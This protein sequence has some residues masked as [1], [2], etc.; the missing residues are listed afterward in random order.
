[1]IEV[2]SESLLRGEKKKERRKKANPSIFYFSFFWHMIHFRY[3]YSIFPLNSNFKIMTDYA[4]VHFSV[5]VFLWNL[6]FEQG[7]ITFVFYSV[8]FYFS[9]FESA[10]LRCRAKRLFYHM[11]HKSR[12][13]NPCLHWV[14]IIQISKPVLDV[15]NYSHVTWFVVSW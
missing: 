1:M 10:T 15:S 2:V 7:L 4:K 11:K 3:H 5:F 13:C 12:F 9:E 14:V 6:P 8:V